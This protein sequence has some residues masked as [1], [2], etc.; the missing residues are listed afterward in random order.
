VDETY[1]TLP[2]EFLTAQAAEAGI[3]VLD[4][5]P[6]FR[7]ACLEKLGGACHREDRYLFADVWMHPSAYG[8]QLAA[9]ALESM[10]V[11]SLP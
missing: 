8:H 4:L 10:F 1:P 5:L 6:A 3:P 9:A 2:Q 11:P 7:Q